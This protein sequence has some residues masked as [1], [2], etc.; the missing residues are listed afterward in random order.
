MN[1]RLAAMMTDSERRQRDIA[2]CAHRGDRMR[3]PENTI[4]AMRAAIE[5]GVDAVEFD[6]RMSRD[7]QIVVI[8]DADLQRC[9]DGHG[10]VHE[11]SLKELRTLDAGAWF[12]PR[13]RGERIPTLP[14]ALALVRGKALP[15]IEIKC[16]PGIYSRELEDLLLDDLDAAG[17]RYSVV[18]HSFDPGIIDRLHRS[19]SRL[20]LGTTAAEPGD[21]PPWVAG[22][23][24]EAGMV[25]RELVTAFHGRGQWVC[26]WTVNDRPA[27]ESAIRSGVDGIMTDDPK[28]L[29]DV[30]TEP[31]TGGS[32]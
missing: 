28:L 21:P 31:S 8:H 14:Q 2:V 26:A 32:P 16:D 3:A 4:S 12:A 6:I 7:R 15:M 24:P 13:F 17:M 1:V 20:V 22:F 30:V 29:L 25:T 18:L 9:S 23:H 19:D 11:R 10:P 27:M 5:L